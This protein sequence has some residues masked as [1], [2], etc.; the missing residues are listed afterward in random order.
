MRKVWVNSRYWNWV[1]SNRDEW[2]RKPWEPKYCLVPG[3]S[4][5][6]THRCLKKFDKWY[7]RP[8]KSHQLYWR[9]HENNN[10]K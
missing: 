5:D 3:W 10:S 9:L 8:R 2:A 6:K 7:G 4:G 1:F